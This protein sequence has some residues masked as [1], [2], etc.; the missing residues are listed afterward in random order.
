MDI[1]VSAFNKSRKG[2]TKLIITSLKEFTNYIHNKRLAL[3]SNKYPQLTDKQVLINY[4]TVIHSPMNNKSEDARY[5]KKI[6]TIT[7]DELQE[8]LPM[9]Q[10]RQ[11]EIYIDTLQ[12][13]LNIF[14][15]IKFHIGC[16]VKDMEKLHSISFDKSPYA[17]FNFNIYDIVQSKALIIVESRCF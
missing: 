13:W 6:I 5:I 12:T 17:L 1:I 4:L 3:G 15:K 7:G 2:L 11:L 9:D 14:Y 16:Y 10:L 8:H